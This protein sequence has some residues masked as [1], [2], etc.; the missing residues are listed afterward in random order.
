MYRFPFLTPVQGGQTLTPEQAYATTSYQWLLAIPVRNS[1]ILNVK[2]KHRPGLSSIFQMTILPML[3]VFVVQSR[4]SMQRINKY[5]N[6]ED[7]PAD[8]V[9]HDASESDPIIIERGTFRWDKN[10]PVV[11]RDVD[12]HL[13]RGSLTA[14][15]GMVGSGK[16]SLMSALLGDMVKDSGSRVNT[17][18]QIAYVPQQAWMRN[19]K[20]RENVLFG[21]SRDSDMYERVLHACALTADLKVL[22]GGDETEIGEKGINLSGGQKQR[23]SLARACYSDADLYLL[24]DPLSAVDAHVGKHIFEQV[25]GPNGMLKGKTRVLVTHSIT[26]LHLMDRII[27]LKDNTISEQGTYQELIEKKGAFADFLVEHMAGMKE[28]EEE[29]TQIVADLQ[30][31]LGDGTR[32]EK[33]RSQLARQESIS[34]ED[35]EGERTKHMRT[36]DRSSGGTR[37]GTLIQDETAETGSVDKAVYVYYLKSIGLFGAILIVMLQ[38]TVQSASLGTSLWMET[39]VAGDLGNA[40]IPENRN[41][42]LSVY[43][44]LGFVQM[45][46]TLVLSIS[47][48]L[49]TLKASKKLHENM[50][51]N[52]WRNPMEFFDTTPVGRILNRFSSDISICDTVLA[53]FMS[54]LLSYTATF[55]GSVVVFMTVVWWFIAFMIPASVVFIVTQ[56]IYVATSRQL[57]RLTSITKSPIFTHFGETLNGTSTI[58]AYA[59]QAK[60]REESGQLIDQNGRMYYPSVI[61]NRWLA[62]RLETL[63]NL[64][65]LAVSVVAMSVEIQ[66]SEAGLIISYSLTLSQIMAY[67]VRAAVDVENNI[68]AVERIKEYTHTSSEAEW[69]SDDPPAEG[70]PQEGQVTFA[71]YGMRYREGLPLAIGGLDCRING[72]EKVGIVGR[73]G[74]GKSSLTVALFRMAEAATGSISI[75]GVDIS[76]IGL[77]ELRHK[78]TIIPQDPVLFAGTLRVN[79]D[80]FEAHSDDE[81]WKAL[82]LSHLKGY[83]TGIEGGLQ[84][85]ITEGGE[86]LSVGQRQMVCLARALLRKTKILILDEATAAVDLE[87]DELIQA[88]IRREFAN[89]TVLTIAHRLNTIMDY[90]K[91]VVLDKGTIKEFAPPNQLL[92]NENSIFFGMARN[93]KLI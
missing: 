21:R 82:E 59:M 37:V 73:T 46:S 9:T 28:D 67:L 41:L 33:L 62:V 93:A 14:V 77:H 49:V 70:W 35:T 47:I 39:W 72:G 90:D 76:K 51:N 19:A 50:L 22:P 2:V 78:L 8:S 5:M 17:L 4:V 30:D 81:L 6:S 20:L 69:E 58:R 85:T 61:A 38:L 89:C 12:I 74:A 31:I 10:E 52:V 92:Q 26:H 13:E 75:D 45:I 3:L 87:T 43:G 63:G 11:L 16:S 91:I 65:T 29:V 57:K 34:S 64:I 88:T 15:V 83:V 55:I 60:M 66:A 42:Y 53:Q 23:I 44:A 68:V 36:K 24:D 27:V 80:P 48:S 79:L 7:I 71:D 1:L 84:H 56:Q 18:G 86:N 40:S 54:Q 25:L 32:K